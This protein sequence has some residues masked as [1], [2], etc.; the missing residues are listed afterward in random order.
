MFDE[1]KLGTVLLVAGAI[2]VVFFA[3]FLWLFGWGFYVASALAMIAAVTIIWWMGVEDAE[4]IE[5][6]AGGRLASLPDRAEDVPDGD[7]PV[8][9]A[10]PDNEEPSGSSEEA[11]AVIDEP[12]E[13]AASATHDAT[14]TLGE[15]PETGAAPV[16]ATPEPEDAPPAPLG[17]EAVADLPEGRR[18]QLFDAPRGEADDLKKI[19]GIGPKLEARLN[20]MGVWHFEQIAAWSAEEIAWVDDNLEFKGRVTRDD[21]VGQAR[22][23]AA[24]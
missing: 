8:E 16:D 14:T 4:T 2:F 6:E 1:G 24:G 7:D 15:A 10:P 12:A 3:L 23:L 20:D 21:W 5:D 22:E 11:A 19:R 9:T 17:G 18:P 13:P